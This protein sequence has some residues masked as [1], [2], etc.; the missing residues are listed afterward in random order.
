MQARAFKLLNE[1]ERAKLAGDA[2]A[3]LAQWM[4]EWSE[5]R[6]AAATLEAPVR[7][8]DATR[9]V[10]DAGDAGTPVPP[11]D[12]LSWSGADGTVFLPDAARARHWT[13]RALGARAGDAPPLAGSLAAELIERA[14][15]DLAR[16]LAGSPV[17]PGNASPP[18]SLRAPGSGAASMGL[19]SAAGELDVVLDAALVSHRLSGLARAVR[20]ESAPADPRGC[21]GSL[22]VEIRAWLGSAEVD[23]AVLQTLAVGDVVVLDGCLDQPLRVSVAGRAVAARAWLGHAGER[24]AVR[25]AGGAPHQ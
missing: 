19:P 11:A 21:L 1:S 5:E 9:L 4:R 20:K 7:V 17:V 23:V 10:G 3:A 24:K 25:L 18:A 6:I 13:A 16:R 8:R 15:G 2:T 12:A 22:P 14:L